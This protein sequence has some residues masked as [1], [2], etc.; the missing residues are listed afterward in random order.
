MAA[1]S[2]PPPAVAVDSTGAAGTVRPPTS[3]DGPS[4]TASRRRHPGLHSFFAHIHGY[5]R[6][7]AA[8]LLV[9]V[10]SNA[11]LAVVP[12]VVG[13]FVTALTGT[14]VD[15]STAFGWAAVL[16]G[17]SVGHD[18]LYRGGE[19]LWVRLLLPRGYEY[20]DLVFAKVINQPYPYFVGTFTGKISSYVTTLGREYRQFLDAVYWQ[21]CEEIV[22]VPVLVAIM[23][24]VNLPTGC[25]FAGGL[26]LMIFLGRAMVAQ[27]A[28]RERASADTSSDLEG[29]VIDVIA[30]FVAV[31]SFGRERA[32]NH[33]VRTR[34]RG[35]ARAAASSYRWN[36]VYFASMSVVV[37]Y[38]LWPATV[39]FNL[40][41]YLDGELTLGQFATFLAALMAFSDYIWATVW[42]VSQM[43]LQFAR[44]EEAYRYLFGDR[45][46]VREARE[47]HEDR[48]DHEDRAVREDLEDHKHQEDHDE[49]RLLAA[50]VATYTHVLRLDDLC[51]AYPDDPDR[52]VLRGI[53]LDIARNEKIGVVGQSG[54]GKSTLLKLL[55]GY[56][57]LPTGTLLLDGSPI[58]DRQL[59]RLISY[60]PQD[61][62]LFHRSIR[63]NIIYGTAATATPDEVVAAARRAHAHE[64]IV[65]TR[66]GYETLVGERGIRLSTG[67]RQRIALARAFLNPAPILVLDEA[68]SALDSESERL[69]QD[70]LEDLWATRTVI[71]IAHRLSTLLTMDRIVVLDGGRIAEQGTHDE[72]LAA[73]GL[74]NHL[75]CRQSGGLIG[76][77]SPTEPVRQNRQTTH[78]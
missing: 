10:L 45:D 42:I 46:I 29:H 73:G 13:R 43:N 39:L 64:F 49:P 35:V 37:R 56:Y 12:A 54:S 40:H 8:V 15:H 16:I 17:A 78:K 14:S 25:V 62:T 65:A 52:P 66:E 34:R 4:P 7:A 58:D 68:T 57:P 27:V 22:R 21:Y 77:L 51:F 26:L 20:E 67:Q 63:E 33:G 55:L 38:V 44:V 48:E 70:A 53:T 36:L 47:N 50:P 5:R 75:W 41:L 19:L 72:L 30:N 59:A 23:F 1:T 28:A 9:F 61:V 2:T 76:S 69:V 31:K 32:E 60:V 24:T 74:Y 11:L 6:R 3:A 18:L 71:A